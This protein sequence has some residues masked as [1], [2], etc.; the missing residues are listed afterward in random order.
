MPQAILH[1]IRFAIHS[2]RKAA[3]SSLVSIAA[4]GLGIGVS[5]AMLDILDATAVRTLPFV[6]A[7]RL[8]MLRATDEG[9]IIDW[10]AG[11][12][13]YDYR[14]RA[15][16]F[17]SL[18]SILAY[19]DTY[20]ITGRVEPE[21]VAGTTVSA[22]LFSAL[23]VQPQ[24][25]RRFATEDGQL[26][27][28][29]VILISQDLSVRRFGS[30]EDALGQS[31][32]VNGSPYTVVGV[33]P[34]RFHFWTEVHIWFPM[35][36]DR[37]FAAD[38]RFTN[39][40][41]VGRL[42]SEVTRNQ[43]QSQVD[44]I[45]AQLQDAYP[46]T[47][48]QRAVLLDDLKD[49]LLEDHRVGLLILSGAVGLVLLIACANV[50]G[51][52]LARAPTRSQELS[53]RAALG[54]GRARLC[55]Q[56]LIENV[57]LAAGGGLLG[58]AI[59]S[60]FQ[61]VMI[62][63]LRMDRLAVADWASPPL[64][65]LTAVALTLMTGLISGMY[66]AVH[67]ARGNI[68]Q[69]IR[70][71]GRH[72]GLGGNAFRS[73]L[74]VTQVG[75]SV[76]LLVGAALLIRSLA[77]LYA[78]DVGINPRNT[79]TFEV[80]LPPT[81]YP[82]AAARN[83]FYVELFGM[84]RSVPGVQ[85]VAMTT[86]LPIRHYGNM[87]P[88]AVPG[89]SGEVE[90]AFIRGILPG[91]FVSMGIPV[92][93]GRG[94]MREDGSTQTSMMDAYFNNPGGEDVTGPPR[95]AV[96][97]EALAQAIFPDGNPLGKHFELTFGSPRQMEVVGVVGNVKMNALDDDMLSAVYVPYYQFATGRMGIA[98]RSAIRPASLGGQIRETV[99][100]LDRNIPVE[101]ISTMERDIA[102]S[103]D[104]RR[105]MALSVALYAFL[106][107]LLAGVGLYAVI[108][109][110]VAQRSHEIGIR[111]TLGADSSKVG[112]LIMWRGARLVCTGIATGL[113]GAIWLSRFLQ[114][115]LFG[116][117]PTDPATYLSV[118]AFVV[119]VAFAACAVPTWQ[120]AHSDPSAVLRAT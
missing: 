2:L 81:Q 34:A 78:Q 27:A 37:E 73:A 71:G 4:L 108:A 109:Y 28:P 8:V 51:M 74:V 94:L 59:A 15:D 90:G 66:P 18:A 70:D 65:V 101:G 19:G 44:L 80:Q 39:W 104:D 14:D 30:R 77:S 58:I 76:V 110:Y 68:A 7:D 120:A 5:L 62:E 29:D 98:L 72:S 16:A 32:T 24:V 1:D 93:L 113:L 75:L 25:G 86:N 50:T 52:L 11:P 17:E 45:A 88:A 96:I 67:S 23:Q 13:Y 20:T 3:L 55:R 111:M 47:N 35:R 22:N 54:A 36:P 102:A 57:F 92:L 82:D 85:S 89:E 84:L 42:A 63:L 114:G 10:F 119:L 43:A 106:P 60:L 49:A 38:R 97:S 40:M 117:M 87:V 64:T 105:L 115:M 83:S 12:D 100:S 107:L 6:E 26:G 95:P 99:W 56:L 116:V 46:E 118:T 9:N 69:N 79:V 31:L 21:R 112:Q 53:I 91:Y 41:L 48:A 33:M 61:G 103:L